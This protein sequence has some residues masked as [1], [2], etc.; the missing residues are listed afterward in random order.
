MMNDIVWLS[1]GGPGSGRYPKGSGENPRSE[2]R[3]K[4]KAIRSELH[5]LN[6]YGRHKARLD[7]ARI[8]THQY[9]QDLKT[10]PV[11]TVLKGITYR[12][13]DV[14]SRMRYRTQGKEKLDAQAKAKQKKINDAKKFIESNYN[15]TL[16]TVRRPTVVGASFRVIPYLETLPKVRVYDKYKLNKNG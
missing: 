5:T 3:K 12:G 10:K 8:Q 7:Y 13:V 6:K 14:V 11:R 4:N 1:H 16:R 9:M 15:V 2:I